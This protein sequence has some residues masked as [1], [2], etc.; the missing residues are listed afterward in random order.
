V[1]EAADVDVKMQALACGGKPCH[2]GAMLHHPHR[3]V[4][5]LFLILSGCGGGKPCAPPKAA[6]LAP[7]PKDFDTLTL[8]EY[9]RIL[10]NGAITSRERLRNI[11]ALADADA[12]TVQLMA[13]PGAS[14][15]MIEAMRLSMEQSLACGKGRC[16]E[17]A[18]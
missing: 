6:W 7:A 5:C 13:K 3:I 8:D 2:L 18:R 12:R 15:P 14:C 17:A 10:W 9:D 4:A 1:C 11:L 16:L